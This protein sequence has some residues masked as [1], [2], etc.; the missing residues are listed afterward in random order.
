AL[1]VH[2][3]NPVQ[4]LSRKQVAQIFL[5]KASRWNQVGGLP[6]TIKVFRA[7]EGRGSTEM[8]LHYVG[9]RYVEL[10]GT[11]TLGDNPQRIAALKADPDAIIFVSVSYAELAV[12]KGEP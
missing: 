7:E 3:D 2:R 4:N 5:G 9:A 10:T 12:A 1:V 6:R 8:M 11:K